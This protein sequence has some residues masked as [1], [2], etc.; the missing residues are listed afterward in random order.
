LFYRGQN[1]GYFVLDIKSCSCFGMF[2]SL[3]PKGVLGL[4]GKNALL[5]LLLVRGYILIR[6]SKSEINW[7]KRII[8]VIFFLVLCF[9][10]FQYNINYIENYSLNH[11]NK[12]IVEFKLP[13]NNENL[14][15]INRV[16]FFSPTCSH[17]KKV[18]PKIISA[19]ELDSLNFI[20]VISNSNSSKLEN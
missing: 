19:N 4:L 8:S 16:F 13:M 7:P 18:I 14:S 5:F 12:N 10:S 11:L 1:N 9:T 6:N 15:K 3:N 20:G 2:E 17:C